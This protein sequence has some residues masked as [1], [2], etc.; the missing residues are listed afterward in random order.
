MWDLNVINQMKNYAELNN[1][2]IM[3]ESG[4]RYLIKYI[5]KNNV[6]RVLE[7]GTAIGYSAIMMCTADPELMVTTIERDEKR[8][9]EAL[10]NIKKIGLEDRIQLIYKD[11][12]EVTLNDY[13]D[14]IVID[15]AKDQNQKFFERFEKNLVEDGTIITDNIKFHGLVDKKPDEIESR[16]LRQLVRKVKDYIHFLN[17][18][19]KYET[20]FLDVG[21]GLAVSKKI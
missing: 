16:N 13:Y 6:K 21:D 3:T 8:Y 2:P 18:N 9:L 7:I 1:V 15:A 12:L 4:I 17:F 14:L 19:K 5:T 10:K 20:E 11:A